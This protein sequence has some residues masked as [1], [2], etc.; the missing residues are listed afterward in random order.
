MQRALGGADWRTI[1]NRAELR[2][3]GW[4][5]AGH[6][7]LPTSQ[8]AQCTVYIHVLRFTIKKNTQLLLGSTGATHYNYLASSGGADR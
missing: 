5:G 7:N 1:I 6:A 8:L 4:E 2:E 3:G